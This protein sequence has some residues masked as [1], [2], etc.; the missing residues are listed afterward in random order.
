ME[1]DTTDSAIHIERRIA[2]WVLGSGVGAAFCG[3]SP[4][5]RNGVSSSTLSSSL[6]RYIYGEDWIGKTNA[7]RCILVLTGQF[8]GPP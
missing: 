4:F 3:T 5:W 6:V 2:I 8:W 1:W 7:I